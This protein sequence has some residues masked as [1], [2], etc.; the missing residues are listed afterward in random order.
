MTGAVLATLVAAVG[1]L[2][3]LL[4]LAAE[5]RPA[6]GWWAW[7]RESV[8]AWRAEELTGARLEAPT[9]READLRDLFDLGEPVDGPAY[10]RPEAVLARLGQARDHARGALRR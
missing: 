2:S 10:A 8:S 4:I 9:A 6:G 1:A 3:I 5:R 7:L